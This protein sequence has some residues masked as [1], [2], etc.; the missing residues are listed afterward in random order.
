MNATFSSAMAKGKRWDSTRSTIFCQQ[1]DSFWAGDLTEET[2][3]VVY[4]LGTFIESE[5]DL[6][7]LVK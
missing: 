2:Q 7:P 3:G 6:H 5:G 4:N 1:I